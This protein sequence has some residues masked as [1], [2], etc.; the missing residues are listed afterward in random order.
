MHFCIQPWTTETAILPHILNDVF[1]EIERFENEMSAC[2][3]PAQKGSAAEKVEKVIEVSDDSKLAFSLDV[4]QFKPEELKVSIDGRTLAV[5]GKQEVKEG[6]SY[7]ARTFLQRWTLPEDVD[8]DQIRS[9]LNENGQL[10]IEVPKAK[11][12]VTAREIPIQKTIDQ[13]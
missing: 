13:Q 8:V 3:C 11:P 5:E 2:L 9:T 1:S 4:S 12:A 6:S 7:T 10:A